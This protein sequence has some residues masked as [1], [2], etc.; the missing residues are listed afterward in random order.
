MDI[1]ATQTDDLIACPNCDV[2]YRIKAP[3][4]GERARC[5]RCHEVLITP[6]LGAEGRIIALAL[7]VLILTIGALSFPFLTIRAAGVSHS[8]SIFSAAAAFS[9][10]P[11]FLLSFAV[12]CLIVLVP[13]GRVLLLL[14]VFVPLARGRGV[15]PLTKQAFTLA[16]RMR[17]WSMAEIFAIGC[18]VAL[19]K[20]ADL[21]EIA[22]GPA[23]WMFALLTLLVVAQD[24]LICRWTIWDALD[25]EAEA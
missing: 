12:L 2:L 3:A 16:E 10:G 8:A 23:F 9:G 22:F 13:V 14:Y 7:A 17:P 24:S 15:G 20:V 5:G 25:K 11:F 6:R 1:S 4:R 21:A 18:A 19:V